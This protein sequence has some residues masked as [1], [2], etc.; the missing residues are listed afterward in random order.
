MLLAALTVGNPSTSADTPVPVSVLPAFETPQTLDTDEAP[1]GVLQGDRDDP[2]IWVHPT[3]PEQSLVLASLKNGGLAVFE[4]A[5]QLRQLFAPEEY[6][7]FR[8]NNVDLVYN[9][10]LGRIRTDIAVAT[11][12]ANDTLVVFRIDPV[13]QTLTDITADSM[14]AAIFEDDGVHTAYGIAT[15]TSPVSGKNYAFVA[16]RAG[17]LVAQLE[18]IDAGDGGVTAEKV[19]T[20]ELPIFDNEPEDSQPEG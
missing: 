18:L 15:Y 7:A 5:G 19:R 14:P 2:A 8:Y 12:R 6:G 9:F 1:P 17:N 20:M 16:K 11:D 3:H 13:T 4:L 10:K